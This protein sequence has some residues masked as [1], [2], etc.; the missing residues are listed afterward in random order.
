MQM[1]RIFGGINMSVTE[2]YMLFTFDKERTVLSTSEYLGGINKLA[3]VFNQKLPRGVICPSDLPGGSIEQYF[4]LQSASLGHKSMSCLLTSARMECHGHSFLQEGGIAV[5]V[6]ATGGV[7][8]NAAR[9]GELPQYKETEDGFSP[10]GGT[11]NLFVFLSFALSQGLLSKTLI[12]L[13][14]AKSA[15][16]AELGVYSTYGLNTA[17]GTG[18]DGIIVVM[19]DEGHCYNDVGTHSEIGWMLAEGVK[20]AV[21]E[22]LV[23]ECYWSASAQMSAR[24][25]IEHDAWSKEAKVRM[26]GAFAKFSISEREDLTEALSIYYM[27]REKLEFGGVSEKSYEW[28]LKVVA[29]RYPVLSVWLDMTKNMSGFENNHKTC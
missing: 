4:A 5:E 16:L 22:T 21:A 25:L 9:A 2:N 20:R 10:L 8:G 6:F 3:G 29:E 7:E 11:I 1:S 24:R 27:L 13:T 28:L 19:N 12:T 23:K 15:L 14:E 26:H 18:T 17:T